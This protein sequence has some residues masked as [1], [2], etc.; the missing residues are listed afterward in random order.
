MSMKALVSVG[1]LLWPGWVVAQQ[2]VPKWLIAHQ[3]PPDLADDDKLAVLVSKYVMKQ[4]QGAGA[5]VATEQEIKKFCLE[6]LANY[7]VPREVV[8]TS[9]APADG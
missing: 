2:S 9:S 3:F 6:R 5:V 1:L 4:L 7:K 8:F